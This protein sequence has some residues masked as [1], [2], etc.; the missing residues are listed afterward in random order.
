M[1]RRIIRK[2]RPTPSLTG[3]SLEEELA[4]L[5][6]EL[7]Y[8]LRV[9][10]EEYL[11]RKVDEREQLAARMRDGDTATLL[12]DLRHFLERAVPSH[13]PPAPV[14]DLQSR[15]HSPPAKGPEPA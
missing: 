15:R 14:V 10:R 2:R 3:I 13:V 5:R 12:A 1:F 9:N 8:G 7:M 6:V 11:R 4:L